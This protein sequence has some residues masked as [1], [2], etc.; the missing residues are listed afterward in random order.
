MRRFL[1]V[2]DQPAPVNALP[3]LGEEFS[4]RS[5]FH[6]SVVLLAAD[7]AFHE[8]GLLIDKFCGVFFPGHHPVVSADG[9]IYVW[10]RT[11]LM[12]GIFG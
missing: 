11:A 7:K 10:I 5:G 12:T 9:Q 4:V 8:A 6:G 1:I 2:V 3:V